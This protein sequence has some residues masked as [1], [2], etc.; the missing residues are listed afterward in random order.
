MVARVYQLLLP[1]LLL[2]EQ[3]AQSGAFRLILRIHGRE[4]AVAGCHFLKTRRFLLLLLRLVTRPSPCAPR[5][6]VGGQLG[7]H[8]G[9]LASSLLGFLAGSS[10]P[11]VRL[12]GEGIGNVLELAEDGLGEPARRRKA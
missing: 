8:S 5:G 12:R 4:I 6:Q 10:G 11:S 1:D 7:P 3:G 2:E 9:L